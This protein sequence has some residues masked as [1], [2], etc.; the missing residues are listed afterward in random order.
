M[1]VIHGAVCDSIVY[2]I[3]AGSY[4]GMHPYSAAAGRQRFGSAIGENLFYTG[5]AQRSP[6]TCKVTADSIYT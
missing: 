3:S 4:A 1:C 5:N 2:S 6:V